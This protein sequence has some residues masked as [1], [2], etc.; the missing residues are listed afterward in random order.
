MKLPK[1]SGG[2]GRFGVNHVAEEKSGILPSWPPKLPIPKPSDIIGN[3]IKHLCQASCRA[4]QVSAVAGCSGTTAAIA[5]CAAG[6]I[7]AGES[8]F[9]RC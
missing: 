6:A 8:C 5:L 3:P 2:V 1:M 9:K 4:A 7:A